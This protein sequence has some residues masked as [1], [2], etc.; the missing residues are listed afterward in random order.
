VANEIRADLVLKYQINYDGCAAG[1]G[2]RLRSSPHAL[3]LLSRAS[4]GGTQSHD[5]F[6][7]GPIHEEGTNAC[8]AGPFR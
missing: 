8:R 4:S 3:I 6:D 5:Q 2:R 7:Y 1:C